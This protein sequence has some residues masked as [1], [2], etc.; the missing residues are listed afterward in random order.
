MS[1]VLEKCQLREAIEEKE[2]GLDSLGKKLF[3]L[4][5]FSKVRET[6]TKPALQLYKMEQTGAW[7]SGNY[8]VWDAL[9]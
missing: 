9:C 1:K 5:V 3:T 6:I 4:G 7:D 8:F 2:E